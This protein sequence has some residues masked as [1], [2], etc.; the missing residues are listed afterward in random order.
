MIDAK[1][2]ILLISVKLMWLKS[3]TKLWNWKKK[4]SQNYDI[5]TKAIKEN[6]DILLMF[7]VIIQQFHYVVKF[8]PLS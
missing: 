6:A 1:R 7:C 8:P 2:T 5:P 3:K 4:A